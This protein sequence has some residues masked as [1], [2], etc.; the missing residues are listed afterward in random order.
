MKKK[1]VLSVASVALVAALAIGSTLAYFT[2]SDS[3]ANV[4]TMGKVDIELT[5]DSTDEDAVIT[6]DGITYDDILPGDVVSKIPTITVAQDSADAYI[7]VKINFINVDIDES[8]WPTA[9]MPGI[10]T[11]DYKWIKGT[12]GYYYYPAKVSASD[13]ITVFD[14]T[15]IPASWGNAFAGKTF[16]IT[17]KAEAVQADNFNVDF[18]SGTPCGEGFSID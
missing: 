5:E 16:K 14:N 12:D 6:D 8:I 15:T 10:N 17:I 4:L 11:E 13:K 2:D 7:R 3:A 9:E 18:T 1:L